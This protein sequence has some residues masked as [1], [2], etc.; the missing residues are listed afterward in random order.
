M[1]LSIN[2]SNFMS[3]KCLHTA[4]IKLKSLG[5]KQLGPDIYNNKTSVYEAICF[6]KID[7]YFYDLNLLKT[8]N[9]FGL[10]SSNGQIISF[11]F[12]ENVKTSC[13]SSKGMIVAKERCKIF[14]DKIEYEKE[15]FISTNP[16]GKNVLSVRLPQGDICMRNQNGLIKYITTFEITCDETVDK[17]K[18]INE[19][20]FNPSVCINVIKMRSKYGKLY[21]LF[22]LQ[23]R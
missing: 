11:D 19:K 6:I 12:C 22:S 5:I 16:Q 17:V 20:D 13:E 2:C 21:L 14:P 18:I 9:P 4:R 1:L 7:D 15:W 10:Y 3:N 23:K 8:E